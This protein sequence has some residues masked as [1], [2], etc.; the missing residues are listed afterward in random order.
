[1]ERNNHILGDGILGDLMEQVMGL[2]QDGNLSLH[3]ALIAQRDTQDGD[4]NTGYTEFD[5]TERRLMTKDVK[6][7]LAVDNYLVSYRVRCN[8]HGYKL[9][10]EIRFRKKGYNI[11]ATGRTLQDAKLSFINKMNGPQSHVSTRFNDIAEDFFTLYHQKK[12]VPLL[13]KTNLQAYQNHIAP[14]TKKYHIKQVNVRLCHTILDEV[15]KTP[16]MRETVY[17]LLN[18]IFK[19]AKN[20]VDS[21][22]EPMISVNPM[23]AIPYERAKREHSEPLSEAEE[24]KILE[25]VAGTKYEPHIALLLYTGVRIGEVKTIE[26][27]DGTKLRAVNEKRKGGKVEYK[28]LPVNPMLLPYLESIKGMKKIGEKYLRNKI[29]EILGK[30]RKP[31]DFRTTFYTRCDAL[32]INPVVRDAVV[33]H[34]STKLH[35]TYSHLSDEQLWTEMQKFKY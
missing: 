17:C 21:K 30:G 25:S 9:N 20:C 2:I 28:T 27:I 10:Y 34:V 12:V 1:M 24:K 13:Y 5:P 14:F 3:E 22:G 16:R 32:A 31:K 19:Y 8:E 4:R 7:V 18:Q 6:T 23:A 11:S 33:G 29:H 35:A 15:K 26:V